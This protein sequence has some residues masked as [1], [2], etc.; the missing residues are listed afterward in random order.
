LSVKIKRGDIETIITKND[1]NILYLTSWQTN[2]IVKHIFHKGI[3]TLYTYTT[4]FKIKDNDAD[5]KSFFI[6][7]ETDILLMDY[8]GFI[9]AKFDN[10]FQD[11]E[12]LCNN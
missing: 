10:L 5:Q 11:I 6:I 9:L 4:K 12:Y 2:L 7:T 1:V 8:D 3:E